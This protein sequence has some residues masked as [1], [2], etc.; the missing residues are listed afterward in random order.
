[1]TICRKNEELEPK[2]RKKR[3]S[4]GQNTSGG[5]PGAFS[6][7][8]LRFVQIFIETFLF[9]K[10]VTILKI[11]KDSKIAMY[12]ISTFIGFWYLAV[13]NSLQLRLPD[14]EDLTPPHFL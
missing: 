1:L 7:S 3:K 10:K 5:P 14:S 6:L 11:Q 9:Y 12:L 2:R 4:E 8:Q 13:D